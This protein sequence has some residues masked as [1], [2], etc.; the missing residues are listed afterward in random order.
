MR[1]ISD[2]REY[3][4]ICKNAAENENVFSNFKNNFHYNA[5][6]EHVSPEQGSLYLNY[7]EKNF[8]EYIEDLEKF[9]MNDRYGNAKL[10]EYTQIGSI[11][12]STLRY[13]KVL[14][15]LKN[16]MGDLNGKKIIEIGPGYGGQCFILSQFFKD[17]DYFLV[18]MEESLSLSHKYLDKL[19]VKHQIIKPEEVENLEEEFDLVISNYAYSEVDRNFQDRYWEKI[20]KKSK[21]GYFTLNFVSD[22]F[23]IN[24]YNLDEIKSIFSDKK[25]SILEESPKT[26][27]NNIIL[28]F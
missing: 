13:I 8:P 4:D 19:D 24:S 17:L 15:D 26:F 1:S 14:S 27:E 25:Y 18:D 9:K 11:S 21:M 12:P 3:K 5:I 22:I 20:I 6:L 2:R 28:Y 16:L 23:G 10:S 7:L